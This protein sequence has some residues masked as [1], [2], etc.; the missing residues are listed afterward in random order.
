MAIR[1][2]M[3][4]TATSVSQSEILDACCHSSSKC[5]GSAAKTSTSVAGNVGLQAENT[6]RA[7][8]SIPSLGP[9]V[10]YG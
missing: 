4:A 2:S 9:A 3:L 8:S 6:V 1:C 7:F 5:S 10:A